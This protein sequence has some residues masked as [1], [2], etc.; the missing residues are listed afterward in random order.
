MGINL[1]QV[2]VKI[3]NI[4]N[5]H[6]AV[7]GHY[8]HDTMWNHTIFFGMVKNVTRSQKFV[9]DIQLKDKKGH[10]LNQDI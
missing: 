7:H 3:K 9:G 8:I 2:G 1:P 6:P 5:H 4:W 10:G